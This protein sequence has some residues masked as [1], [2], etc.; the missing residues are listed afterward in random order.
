VIFATTKLPALKIHAAALNLSDSRVSQPSNPLYAAMLAH[1]GAVADA[2]RVVDPDRK[3]TVENAI[4]HTQ[5]TALK[6]RK[7]DSIEEQ[8]TWLAHWEERWALSYRALLA[9]NRVLMP[10]QTLRGGI[11]AGAGRC[12]YPHWDSKPWRP[13]A[14]HGYK[15]VF[16]PL[17]AL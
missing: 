16:G 1:Y 3:G 9:T 2:A 7:F 13:Q 5:S 12:Q 11:W 14:A 6:G 15:N 4:Q 8:N 10:S 17:S